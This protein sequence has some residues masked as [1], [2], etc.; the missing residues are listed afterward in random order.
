MS[1]ISARKEKSLAAG[2]RRAP[3]T[4]DAC[5]IMNDAVATARSHSDQEMASS[6]QVSIAS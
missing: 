5:Q 1:L 3:Q 4:F 6:G 2:C